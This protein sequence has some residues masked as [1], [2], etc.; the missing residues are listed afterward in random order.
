MTEKE[1]L[2]SNAHVV[3]GLTESCEQHGDTLQSDQSNKELCTHGVCG[4]YWRLSIRC[5]GTFLMF[6]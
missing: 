4:V 1:M 5:L 3:N 6:I 2:H